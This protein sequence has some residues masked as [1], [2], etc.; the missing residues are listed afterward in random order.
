MRWHVRPRPG[1]FLVFLLILAVIFAYIAWAWPWVSESHRGR[2]GSLSLA[3]LPHRVSAVRPSATLPAPVPSA[4]PPQDYFATAR[5]DEERARSQ[6][7]DLLEQVARDPRAEPSARQMAQEKLVAMSARIDREKEAEILLKGKG[8]ADALVFINDGS[9]V[10]ILKAKQIQAQDVARAA[11]A[12]A[13]VANL[14]ADR[15]NV[16][17]HE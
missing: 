7:I 15:V 14:P 16:M 9:A 17:V 12:V 3:M 1:R 4:V 8:Y 10:V 11:D 13:Q 6:A 2:A 5:L